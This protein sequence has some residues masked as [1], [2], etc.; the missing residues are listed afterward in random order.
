MKTLPNIV[1]HLLPP[2]TEGGQ[3]TFFAQREN[4]RDKRDE[5]LAAA[6]SLQYRR[7]GRIPKLA[8]ISSPQRLYDGLSAS[9]FLGLMF[10]SCSYTFTLT[11][12]G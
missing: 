10:L 12:C 1:Q 7:Q 6:Q 11:P 5:A 2:G 3:S 9:T 8:I 4:T